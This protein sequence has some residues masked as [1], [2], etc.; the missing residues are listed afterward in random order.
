[1]VSN[2]ISKASGLI[3]DSFKDKMES[4]RS[5]AVSCFQ[6]Y[7]LAPLEQFAI[8]GLR[9]FYGFSD[10]DREDG[11]AC[12]RLGLLGNI[13]EWQPH[14]NE[15]MAAALQELDSRPDGRRTYRSGEIF[16]NA[17]GFLLSDTTPLAKVHRKEVSRFL[18]PAKY[19]ALTQELCAE[20]KIQVSQEWEQYK[21]F[22]RI[23]QRLEYL[24]QE[25]RKSQTIAGSY[26]KTGEEVPEWIAN[27]LQAEKERF[28]T[29]KE[30]LQEI[31]VSHAEDCMKEYC[32]DVPMQAV[33]KGLLGIDLS[34][35]EC[36]ELDQMGKDF[37][38]FSGMPVPSSVLRRLP[39]V[40]KLQDRYET[41]TERLL[42][43]E[44]GNVLDGKGGSEGMLREA[45]M[46]KMREN[47]EKGDLH[48]DPELKSMILLLLAVDNLNQIAAYYEIDPSL[49]EEIEN[50]GVLDKGAIDPSILLSKEK[51]PR[52]ERLYQERLE[53]KFKNMVSI[54]RYVGKPAQ[55]GAHKVPART[56]L[57]IKPPALQQEN[58][59]ANVFSQGARSCPGRFVAE[60][61]FK[62]MVVVTARTKKEIKNEL[63]NC[64][65][66][67]EG[68]ELARSSQISIVEEL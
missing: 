58:A 61:I 48:K 64:P 4:M 41:F 3:P 38:K 31:Q 13:A 47:P 25:F 21:E 60:T 29:F 9:H 63:Q 17:S 35:E 30:Y 20:K 42:L 56:T 5:R 24:A 52:L 68:Q 65:P 49:I 32:K 46:Q 26:A 34:H 27:S 16:V 6:N 45:L 62:T 50:S 7:V 33:A 2:I 43:K 57:L 66:R 36:E 28:E 54:V 53:A 1:M 12:R 10:N 40:R 67:E 11:F 37:K 44:I 15:E 59:P 8:G 22:H 55:C 39:Q 51:M 14:T 18:A 23:N 19:A